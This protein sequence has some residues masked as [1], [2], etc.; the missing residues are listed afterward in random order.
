VEGDRMVGGRAQQLRR[1]RVT[2]VDDYVGVAHVEAE[3]HRRRV[4]P[5]LTTVRSSRGL[6]QSASGPGDTGA[7]FSRAITTPSS[8]ARRASLDSERISARIPFS[9][10]ADGHHS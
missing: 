2:Q 1:I 4:Q 10:G 5:R 6:K 3:P 9:S 7:R 8:S